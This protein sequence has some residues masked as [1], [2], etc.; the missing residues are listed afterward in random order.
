MG[1]LTIDDNKYFN[2]EINKV[3]EKPIP[4]C[5]KQ[6]IASEPDKASK[7]IVF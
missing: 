1:S 4:T 2:T 3:D 6:Y 5:S 7:C